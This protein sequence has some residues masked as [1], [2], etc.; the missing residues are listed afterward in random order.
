[1]LKRI[2]GVCADQKITGYS[3]M[4]FDGEINAVVVDWKG[5]VGLEAADGTPLSKFYQPDIPNLIL[6]LQAAYEHKDN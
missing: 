5:I 4:N 2:D 1:M 3:Y 6:A